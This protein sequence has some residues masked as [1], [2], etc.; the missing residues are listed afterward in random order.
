MQAAPAALEI[1]GSSG[2]WQL[3]NQCQKPDSM[4]L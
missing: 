4:V 2:S 3:M 1:T